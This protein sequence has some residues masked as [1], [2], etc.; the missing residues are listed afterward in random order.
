MKDGS[1]FQAP[2]AAPNM[3]PSVLDSINEMRCVI[4]MSPEEL[5]AIAR[6][7]PVKT[8]KKG[9]YLLKEGQIA[10]KCFYI[11][12]GLV[13]EYYLMDG[14]ARTTAFYLEGDS[15]SSNV[16]RMYKTPAKHYWECIE[17]TTVSICTEIAQNELFRQFPR[18]ESL[19]RIGVE[20]QFS[21]YQEAMAIYMISSPAERYLNLLKNKPELLDRVPQYQLASY[22]GV[23]PESLSRIRGRI[24]TGTRQHCK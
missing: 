11:Y 4:A 12:K 15:L 6:D 14:E 2:A 21:Q 7:F 24:R 20:E 13:R 23:K 9:T 19:C 17:E 10:S 16:S 3:V 22:I 5:Q 1:S 8:L 18:F